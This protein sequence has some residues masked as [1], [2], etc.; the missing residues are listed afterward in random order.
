MIENGK[1]I[2]LGAKN[3]IAT[4]KAYTYHSKNIT[5]D[6]VKYLDNNETIFT[7]Y[8]VFEADTIQA[9]FNNKNYN[10]IN[11]WSKTGRNKTTENKFFHHLFHYLIPNLS[12][13]FFSCLLDTYSLYPDLKIISNVPPIEASKRSIKLIFAKQP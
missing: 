3:V 4:V 2:D 6:V 1:I 8:N 13:I 10:P 9:S 5:K 12:L 11:N 7:V